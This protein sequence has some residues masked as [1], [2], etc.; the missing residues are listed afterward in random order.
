MSI[1]RYCPSCGFAFSIEKNVCEKCGRKGRDLKYR[2]MVRT[3]AGQ[4]TKVVPLLSM[5]REIEIAF[6]E[7]LLKSEILGEKYKKEKDLTVSQ[8]WEK[9]RKIVLS[10]LSVDER[11]IRQHFYNKYVDPT[12]GNKKITEVNSSDIET[13]KVELMKLNKSPRTVQHLIAT[14]KHFF[15]KAIEWGIISENPARFVKS[16]RFDN[17]KL[18]F[19]T[20]EEA[21]KL[22]AE[23]KKRNNDI[24]RIYLLV[25]LA[26][27]TGMRRSELFKL[28]WGDI[29]FERNEITV[30]ETKS[31][32]K[33]ICFLAPQVK[34]ELLK[35]KERIKPEK[36]QLLFPTQ[37][38]KM[39]NST[40]T[41]YRK[42]VNELF[43]D[44]STEKKDRVDF[45]TLRHTFCSW[46]AIRGTPLHVIK[47]LA[48]HKSITTTE[49]Y[50][51]L[52]PDVRKVAV[53]EIWR[54]IPSD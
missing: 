16:P 20:Y 8:I 11:R 37:K 25:L 17:R 38:G 54:N 19:L 4:L 45:H 33:R 51:H 43:N 47:E 50:A 6:R 23:C 2:V 31:G 39:Q 21:K 5:A 46:L 7:K 14:L 52:L 10:T 18:R 28:K 22:L 13:I 53:Q 49:R 15:N 26:L 1:Y 42:I 9:Y 29:N 35:L 44:P 32:N 3:K 40:P 48:G 36:D 24:N 34:K 30:H 41:I 27:T 12:I